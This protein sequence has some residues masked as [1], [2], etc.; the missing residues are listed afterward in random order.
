M[1]V[2]LIGDSN[3][4]YEVV[5]Q[6]QDRGANI[7]NPNA[8]RSY[9]GYIDEDEEFERQ[10][11]VIDKAT[12]YVVISDYTAVAKRLIAYAEERKLKPVTV[13]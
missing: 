12:H 10:K 5:I 9:D 3:Q 4:R 2:Y 1:I 13:I 7:L 8:K 6:L 11:K